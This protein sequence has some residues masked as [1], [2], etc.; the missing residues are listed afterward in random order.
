MDG[1]VQR[2]VANPHDQDALAYAHNAGTRDPKSYALFL[3]KVGTLTADPAYA[4]HWLSEAAN[5]WSVTLGDVHR[6]AR[7]L[8][9]AVDKDP[10]QETAADRLAQLYRDN[11]EHKA[12]IAL[13]E[14]RAKALTQL[15]AHNPDYRV[16]LAAIHEELGRLWSEPPLATPKKA[17]EAYRKAVELDPASTYSVY[18]LRELYKQSQQWADALPLYAMEQATAADAE[19]K[20]ALYRDEAQVRKTLGDLVGATEALRQARTIAADDPGLMQEFGSSVLDRL[21]AGEPV[22]SQE[23]DEAIALFV[24][25]AETYPGEHGYAYSC[26]ALDIEPGNDRA[27][28]LAAHYGEPMGRGDELM[29]RWCSYLGV[30]PNGPLAAQAIAHGATPSPV[31]TTPQD[32]IS[33]SAAGG[34]GYRA[35]PPI[36]AVGKP[37]VGAPP[38][39]P[40]GAPVA[41]RPQDG[42]VGRAGFEAPAGAPHGAAHAVPVPHGLEGIPYLLEE[43]AGLASRAQRPQALAKYREVLALDPSNSEALVWVEDYLRQRRQ[44]AELRDVLLQAARSPSSSPDTRKQQLIEVAALCESQLRDLETAISSWKQVCQIDRSDPA[45]PENLRRLLE[46]GARWDELATLLEQEAG[47][48]TDVEQKVALEKKLAH[49]HEIKRKDTVAAG[50]AWARI[51]GLLPGDDTAIL[52]AVKMFEKVQRRDLAAQVIADNAGTIEDGVTRASLYLRLGDL[53]EKA[54][55]TKEAGEAY[56]EAAEANPQLKTWEAAERCLTAASVWDRAAFA[57]GQQAELTSGDRPR[58]ALLA[59]AGELLEKGDDSPNAL[60]YFEGAAGLDPHDEG[61]AAAVHERYT[62][63]ARHADLAD[64]LL[65]RAGKLDDP[66]KRL[67]LRKEAAK[68]QADQ[69]A[70]KTAARETLLRA[71]DDGDDVEVLTTLADDAEERGE[72]GPAREFLARLQALLKAPEDKIRV[73]FREAGLLSESLDDVAGAIDRYGWVLDKVDP[74]NVE[75]LRRTAELEH[76]RDNPKGVAEAY[77]RQLTVLPAEPERLEVARKL[78]DL[79]EGPLEDAKAAVRVLELVHSLDTED[80]EAT[81]RLEALCEKLEN[82]PRVAELLRLLADIEGDEEELSAVTLR[83]AEVQDTRLGRHD[84]ALATILAVADQGD[85]ACRAAYVELGDRLG[86]D[87]DV[88]AKLVEWYSDQSASPARNEA[89]RGAFDRFLAAGRKADAAKVAMELARSKGVDVELATQLEPIAVELKDFEALSVAHSILAKELSGVERATELV[90]QAE[91]LAGAGV[92]S[93]EAQQHGEV[94]LASVP[95]REVWPLLER[96]AAL[97]SDRTLSIEVYE[98]QVGR[99]KTPADRLAALAKAAEVAARF[100]EAEKAQGFFELALGVN[101]HE[102]TLQDLEAGAVRADEADAEMNLRSVLAAAMANGGQSARDGGR[103]RGMLLRRAAQ[104]AHREL[105]D[106]EK[107][108]GWFGEALVAHVEASTLDALEALATEIGDIRRAEETITKALSEVFDGPLVRQLLA[109]R[110]RL[111]R[112]KLA[113]LAGAADDLK[114]LHDVSPGDVAVMEELSQLLVELGDFRGMVHVLEDQILRGKDPAARAELARK[115]ARLWEEKLSDPREAADAWRRVLR[116]KPGDPDAQAGLERAKSG[117]LRRDCEESADSP[118]STRDAAAGQGE[119]APAAAPSG[120]PRR[121]PSFRP[122]TGRSAPPSAPVK[123]RDAAMLT[124]SEEEADAQAEAAVP[125]DEPRR[126]SSPPPL[127]GFAATGAE[128]EAQGGP[129]A[130]AEPGSGP[131]LVAQGGAES[132]AEEVVEDGDQG[133]QGLVDEDEVATDPGADASEVGDEADEVRPAPLKDG[134][135]G[136]VAIQDPGSGPASGKLS[137]PALSNDSDFRASGTAFVSEDGPSEPE[138]ESASASAEP[139]DDSELIADEAELLPDDDDGIDVEMAPPG[140]PSP[141]PLRPRTPPPKK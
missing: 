88:A 67:A 104:L 96:L 1:L 87:G 138:L 102:E 28:Q 108:F 57:V 69:L 126:Q 35:F 20:V 53:R 112:E 141:P 58:A 12:L 132:E 130:I 110:V 42:G 13:L 140:R 3:E 116:M 76:R 56:V 16:Q 21:Q 85:Q 34:A 14:R 62:Q 54:G 137:S 135:S 30:N 98:R 40:L 97:T 66:Q 134:G 47:T 92:D 10:T 73:A 71:L 8:M 7:I 122:T 19:R 41:D 111:R 121:L 17:I 94:G 36:D 60:L 70:D 81:A 129:D 84:D 18:A 83:L 118:G 75:A 6:A 133:P 139:D 45:G 128:T 25:L 29:P 115:V 124:Q 44:Y 48:A 103:T 65:T 4:S 120:L 32:R 106:T 117:M 100:R 107:A 127:P 131:A 78:A 99:C 91:V 5:V 33:S 2:L 61:Y 74:K 80:Y 79:Y 31:A 125:E 39:A 22:P 68:I 136:P 114:K 38:G 51:A 86:Y 37:H 27:M 43:A 119:G 15:A 93:I 52:T 72:P 55:E 82:W 23:R 95:P 26:A 64:F 11:S 77:E 89:L 101:S 90:R 63:A 50:E 105:H 49:L 123:P 113:D 109:R 59:R 9:M 46:R 24:V